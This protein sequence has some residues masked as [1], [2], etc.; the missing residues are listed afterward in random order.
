MILHILQAELAGPAS[1]SVTFSD[2]CDATVDLRPLLSGPIFEPMLDP[3]LFAKFTLDP[4]CKTVCWPNGADLA[5]EAIRA[6]VLT[7]QE[8]G[9]P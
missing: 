1:L 7:E 2:G 9:E 5:P 4:V 3:R 6:L 8:I